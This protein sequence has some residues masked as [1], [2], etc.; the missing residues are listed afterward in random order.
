MD[1]YNR[2]SQADSQTRAVD[3]GL[4]AHMLHVYNYM[5]SA[6][7]F[8]GLIAYF[9]GTSS[10]F[11]GMV[12]Q[13][14]A[15]GRAGLSGLGW[16]ITF[17]PVAMVLFIGVRA[18][19]MNYNT[20]QLCFWGFATLMGLSLFSVFAVYTGASIA[21]V[22]F[23]T[24]GTF[25]LLSIYGYST[26]KDLTSWGTFL[27]V[28]LIAMFF[29]SL[30]NLFLFESSGL[31]MLLSYLG[32]LLALGLTAY[33]T[34]KV[35]ELYYQFGGQGEMAKKASLMGALSLYFDFIYLFVHLLRIMGDRR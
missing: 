12:L 15:D 2:R 10:Q 30:A 6:L 31:S 5:A 18:R 35:K 26:K 3:A 14:S 1:L 27:Q 25:G 8:T 23:I 9:A 24:A 13:V 21:R 29:V 22:F 33:D 28:G 20:L 17:A 32:V 4:R 7:I 11:L 16:L 19:A 34:Q